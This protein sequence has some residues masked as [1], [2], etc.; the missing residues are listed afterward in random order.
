VDLDLLRGIRDA[1]GALR[2]I[3]W[4]RFSRR[5]PRPDAPARLQLCARPS[6]AQAG[7]D[8]AHIFY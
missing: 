8:V 5:H 6:F 2:L 3:V 4:I 1:L 7:S